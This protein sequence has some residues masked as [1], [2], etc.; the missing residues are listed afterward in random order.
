VNAPLAAEVRPPIAVKR[1]GGGPFAAGHDSSRLLSWSQEK[2]PYNP[3]HLAGG[4]AAES[5][6]DKKAV[7]VFKCYCNHC[8]Y[9]GGSI[10]V[11]VETVARETKY[12]KRAVNHAVDVLKALGRITKTSRGIAGLRGG[13][14]SS[15]TRVYCTD[16]ELR[17][18]GA[19]DENFFGRGGKAGLFKA[20]KATD[21]ADS[22]RKP[23]LFKAQDTCAG[24]FTPRT[25]EREPLRTG[26]QKSRPASPPRGSLS[27]PRKRYG[28]VG[29][30]IGCGEE[31][32]RR[33]EGRPSSLAD[34]HED[35]KCL[36]AAKGLPYDSAMVVTAADIALRRLKS[37]DGSARASGAHY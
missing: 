34:L 18:A 14:K 8:D 28:E 24:A 17:S 3:F 16:E 13:R 20:Q 22:K 35:L 36:A 12:S 30:L 26:P 32:L 11:S 23:D 2:K 6:P 15:L 21:R 29:D 7:A 5:L 31:I 19:T 37:R 10:S 1:R 25:S 4:H 27:K 33:V 9:L